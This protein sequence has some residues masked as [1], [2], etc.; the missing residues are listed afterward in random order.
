MTFNLAERYPLVLNVLLAALVIPYFAA[1]SVSEMIKLHYSANVIQ[2]APQT[3]GSGIGGTFSGTRPRS[4][5]NA[6]AERDVF[7]L[8]PAPVETAPVVTNDDLKLTL[9]GTSHLT[10]NRA[11]AIFEDDS[12][13]QQVYRLGQEIPDVGKLVQ[14]GRNRAVIEHNGHRVQ[15]EIPKD[16]LGEPAT[17]DDD[18]SDSDADTMPRRFRR[19][20][21]WTPFIHN[22]MTRPGSPDAKAGGV[23]KLAPNDYAIDRSTM[24]SNMQNL[25]Q[26]FTQIRA[27]PD[28]QNGT[29]QG[30]TLS[31]I[32]PGSIFQE[33]GL[34]DGDIL[35]AVS[36][37]QVADPARAMQM[38]STLQSRSSITLNVLRNGTPV[39]LNYTIH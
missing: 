17:G 20:H 22:P 2:E 23:R 7:N 14:V 9:L 29:S 12:G 18:D 25:P 11:F 35:T 21:L 16:S 4:V 19:R 31:E 10:G 38:L 5:Y 36:G 32:Q 33:L 3:A 13:N 24:N 26:L 30:F 34:Q 27:V 8:A 39:Q 1:R 28:L 6:I 15:I 37:Q